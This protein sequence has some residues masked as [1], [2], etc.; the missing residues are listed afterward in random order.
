MEQT[1]QNLMALPQF[2]ISSINPNAAAEK[3]SALETVDY[4]RA[5]A[6]RANLDDFDSL[7]ARV[8]DTE[9]DE[10]DELQS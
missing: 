5:R 8:P 10:G 1:E 2:P 4:L 9:P 3:L 7:L 6:K